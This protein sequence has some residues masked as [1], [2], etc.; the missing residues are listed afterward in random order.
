MPIEKC[1][2]VVK[3]FSKNIKHSI[4]RCNKEEPLTM[5]FPFLTTNLE[6][7]FDVSLTNFAAARA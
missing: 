2:P 3:T 5:F 6:S 7:H 1:R 4:V